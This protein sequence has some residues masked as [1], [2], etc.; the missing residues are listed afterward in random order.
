[1]FTVDSW[2]IFST[3]CPRVWFRPCCIIAVLFESYGFHL[4][5]LHQVSESNLYAENVLLFYR[6]FM[7]LISVKISGLISSYEFLN[8]VIKYFLLS[9]RKERRYL[10]LIHQIQD[11][12]WVS[13][14]IHMMLTYIWQYLIWEFN[15]IKFD[16]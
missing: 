15:C 10:L 13:T 4:L 7:K 3:A 12:L 16:S 11:Y 14:K 5:I 2:V 8:L 1:M 9:K 6:D